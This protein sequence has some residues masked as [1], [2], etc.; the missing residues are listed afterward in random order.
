MMLVAIS[1]NIHAQEAE[2]FF[3]LNFL[4]V[5]GDFPKMGSAEERLDY[6]SLLQFQKMRTDNMCERAES[7]VNP[8]IE[9]FFV[10]NDGPLSYQ[11]LKKVKIHFYKALV[12]AGL[13]I[14]AAKLYFNRQRPYVVYPDINPCISL[15]KSKSYP[16]GHATLARLYG[17]LLSKFYPSIKS[18]I[19]LRADQVALNRVI[20]GVHHP[21]D[22]IAGT[23]LGDAIANKILND[24]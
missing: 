17:R 12:Y 6:F 19:M 22:I 23:K 5:L 14:E 21:S 24:D 8:S 20:G 4:E 2:S 1:L 9:N 15:E 10:N 7:E 11:E 3:G 13:E 18:K 16:S